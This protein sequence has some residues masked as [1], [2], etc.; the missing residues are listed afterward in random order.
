MIMFGKLFAFIIFLAI[1]AYSGKAADSPHDR[2]GVVVDKIEK[3]EYIP[4]YGST[5]KRVKERG[6]II[7]GAKDSMPGF[8]EELWDEETGALR[9]VGFDIDICRAIAVAVFGNKE[10]VEYEIIDGKTRFIC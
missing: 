6:H 4:T 8:G 5:F 2:S 10:K 7:C 9:F 3:L 1:T